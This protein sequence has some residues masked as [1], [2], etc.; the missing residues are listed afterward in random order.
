ML[1][2]GLPALELRTL[3]VALLAVDLKELM[4]NLELLPLD[5]Q[6]L[7]LDLKGLVLEVRDEMQEEDRVVG[8]GNGGGGVL[9][10]G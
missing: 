3:A 4:G 6:L 2:T 10:G 8:V 5:L 1:V 7:A 9:A